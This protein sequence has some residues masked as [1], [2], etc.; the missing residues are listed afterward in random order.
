MVF[1]LASV[2]LLGALGLA[3]DIGYDLGQRR[4][5]QN[6]ADAAALAGARAILDNAKHGTSTAVRP[7][8][9]SVAIENRYPDN[10]ASSFQCV[11]LDNNNVVVG[12]AVG[13]PDEADPSDVC[14]AA[15]PA[16]ATGVRVAVREAHPTFLVVVLGIGA[17]GTGASAAAHVEDFDPTGF[18][19][20]AGPFIVCGH[21]TFLAPGETD[22]DGVNDGKLS[23]L[24][25]DP[26]T[27]LV[28]RDA[29]GNAQINAAAIGKTFKIHDQ[30]VALC[31]SSTGNG[32]KGVNDQNAN[33][34][35]HL[36][37]ATGTAIKYNPGVRAGPM[38]VAVAGVDGCGTAA[39]TGCRMLLP[40]IE[41]YRGPGWGSSDK[42]VNAV[43]WASF[44]VTQTGSNEHT[45]RLEDAFVVQGRGTRTWSST[46]PTNTAVVR[47]TQ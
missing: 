17:S 20:G 2:V 30:H 33:Q 10:A 19:L 26:T 28:V 27:G 24:V 7:A 15:T 35:K 42:L 5:M 18:D 25:T 34:G 45:G 46:Q 31:D 39:M 13:V 41:A 23:I 40:L 38:R 14:G 8:A 36:G 12:D 21:Q 3:I 16:A 11:Y 22:P 1:A 6:A 4:A 29:D 43:G 9:L 44:W 37:G 32:F 47:L